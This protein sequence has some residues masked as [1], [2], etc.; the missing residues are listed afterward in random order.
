MKTS[1]L[2]N[3]RLI[4]DEMNVLMITKND[5]T[6]CQR[7]KMFLQF[8]L[9]NKYHNDIDIIDKESNEEDYNKLIEEYKVTALPVLICN[10]E[11][12]TR[13]EPSLVVNFLEKH[14]GKK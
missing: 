9:N 12:L 2:T 14:I 6:Q 1:C 3:P 8:A 11:I 10:G 5:C 13:T 7:L 4:G